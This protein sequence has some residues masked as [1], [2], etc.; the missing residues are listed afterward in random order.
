MLWVSEVLIYSL[1]MVSPSL[2]PRGVHAGDD[3]FGR[4]HA[5]ALSNQFRQKGIE[6]SERSIGTP[7][8]VSVHRG[9]RGTRLSSP[10]VTHSTTNTSQSRNNRHFAQTQGIPDIQTSIRVEQ[11]NPSSRPV[12]SKSAACPSLNL[13]DHQHSTV[14]YRCFRFFFSYFFLSNISKCYVHLS[15]ILSFSFFSPSTPSSKNLTHTPRRK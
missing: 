14:E 9:F 4:S 7:D 11:R 1:G 12:A 10:E 13:K 6:L 8:T 5:V 15:S 3:S 2:D